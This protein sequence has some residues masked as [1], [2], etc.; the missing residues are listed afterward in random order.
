VHGGQHHSQSIEAYYVHIRLKVVALVPGRLSQLL[1]ASIA[2]PNPCSSSAQA[3]HRLIK[4]EMRSASENAVG[5]SRSRKR[6]RPRSTPPM[7]HRSSRGRELAGD[8]IECG[9]GPLTN[10]LDVETILEAGEGHREGAGRP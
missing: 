8:G 1:K 6:Q 7:L 5:K 4:Q 3:H 2:D 9:R 10:P